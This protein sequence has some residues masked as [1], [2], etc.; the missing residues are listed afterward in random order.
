MELDI[1]RCV[2]HPDEIVEGP[3]RVVGRLQGTVQS[4]G[5]RPGRSLCRLVLFGE[6]AGCENVQENAAHQQSRDEH[7]AERKKQLGSEGGAVPH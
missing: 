2:Q 5:D 3:A 6:L 4:V 7:Y 1:R